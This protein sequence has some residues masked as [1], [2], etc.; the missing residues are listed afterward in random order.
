[1]FNKRIT[2][3]TAQDVQRL[4]ADQ[5]PEGQ[6]FE[7]K[8]ALSTKDDS[9]DRWHID[10][11]AV[12]ERARNEIVEVVVAFANAY[13][14][15]LLIGI[16]ETDD[17][18]ARTKALA[19]I[20]E[21]IDLAERLRHC[22][23][24]LIVPQIPLLEIGGVP[25]DETGAGVVVIR[26]PRSRAAPH[27][28]NVTR[29]CY[30]RPADRC[31]KMTMREIQ[32]LTLN[33]E[34]GIG[35]IQAKFEERRT[36]F[37]GWMRSN[38]GIG[39]LVTLVPLAPVLLA[40]VHDNSAV[41]PPCSKFSATIGCSPSFDLEFPFRGVT[42]RPALR[43]TKCEFERRD[44]TS[45]IELTCTG[46]IEYSFFARQPDDGE[47]HIYPGWV[48]ALIANALCAAEQF[49]TAASSPS[50]E[51]GLALQIHASPRPAPIDRYGGGKG[52][53]ESFPFGT[54]LFPQYSVGDRLE[55]VSLL[56]NIDLDFWHAAGVDAQD[57]LT[58]DFGRA[59]RELN[60]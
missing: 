42:W 51:Y 11:N 23:R 48:F 6:E 56:A 37:A 47:V 53:V 55:F 9:P 27:R 16:E 7:I 20:P 19:L 21:C 39:T 25:L 54:T 44:L 4:I 28:H 8:Q 22:C 24:D 36:I 5:V 2:E 59:F 35:A 33:L 32:D 52:G 46:I 31:E 45:R 41:R 43:S 15:T 14:G 12:G 30:I 10:Q 18:P 29:E 50:L 3:I 17:K 49:R 13:G 57:P 58:V 40:R 34:R 60:L 38:L 1:V 26:A